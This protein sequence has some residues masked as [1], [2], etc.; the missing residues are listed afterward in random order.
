MSCPRVDEQLLP[1][2]D[3]EAR[4]ELE[5][6]ARGCAQ[7]SARL[8][9]SQN[10][11]K[12]LRAQPPQL[13]PA[14]A[15]AWLRASQQPKRP[16][17]QL[18]APVFIAVA[19][20]AALLLFLLMAPREE[21]PGQLILGKAS[22]LNA[23]GALA[24]LPAS[25][26]IRLEP[27]SEARAHGVVFH[28]RD[29]V[30][31][32]L[33]QRAREPISVAYGRLNISVEAPGF[34]PVITT[35]AGR[36]RLNGRRFALQVSPKRTD[37]EPVSGRATVLSQEPGTQVLVRAREA[38]ARS[39]ALNKTPA[40]P[41]SPPSKPA[42]PGPAVPGPVAP[43]PAAP[44]STRRALKPSAKARV[45]RARA[46]VGRDDRRAVELAERVLAKKPKDP[47]I[48]AEAL[49]IAADGL[50]LRGELQGAERR[51]RQAAEHPGGAGFAEEATLRRAALLASMSRQERAIEVLRD[52]WTRFGRGSLAPERC[53]LHA[54]LL[55]ARG[56][57]ERAQRVLDRVSDLQDRVLDAPKQKL[58]KKRYEESERLRELNR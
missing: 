17:F 48:E 40:A 27:G 23:P 58:L 16:W 34:S 21:P 30:V 8:A 3:A 1:E 20:A 2:L 32:E 25:T 41:S 12:V 36:V 31:L 38:S 53:A 15:Q 11:L 18:P 9:L 43:A 52:A 46:L 49:M 6:H 42:A 39:P 24:T 35:P 37:V 28:A 57:L 55:I 56:E 33:P 13:E 7:C 44:R 4:A 26:W 29:E 5:R 50:R 19:C 47:Q 22:L 51:Y 14:M 45:A 10:T 54:R